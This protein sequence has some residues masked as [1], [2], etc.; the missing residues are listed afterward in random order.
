MPS[1]GVERR[2]AAIMFTDIVGYT[3]LMARDEEAARSARD[4]HEEVVRPLVGRYHG[5]WIERTGDE[6]LS[7]F[8]SALDA[9]NCALAI[10]A[11]LQGDPELRVR[12]GIHQGDVTFDAGGVSGDGVN[13]AARVRP[14]AEAGGICISDEVHH[15]LQGQPDLELESLGERE[16]KHIG[17]PVEV[18]AVK[19]RAAPPRAPAAV[20]AARR[21]SAP[22]STVLALAAL[23]AV[24]LGGWW[25]KR[26]AAQLAPIRSIAVLPLENLSGDPEQEYFADGMTEALIGDLAKLGSLSVISRTSVMRYK[27]SDKSLPEIARELEVDGVLEGTVMRVGDRVRITAQLIDARNDRHLWADRYDREI[28]DVLALQ[29][30]VARAVAEQVRLELT[31]EESEVLVVRRSIDPRAYDAYLRGLQLRGPPTL[32]GGW[33]P[34][35]ITHFERAVELDPGFAEG[36]AALAEVRAFLGVAA[37]NLLY[38][39]EFPKAREAAQRALDL[40]DRLGQ[41]HAILG[42]IRA[43]YDWDFAGAR[44]AYERA[45]KLSPGDAGT[46]NSYAGYLMW[47]EGRPEEAVAISERIVR[48]A[49]FDLFYRADRVRYFFVAHQYLRALDEVERVRELAPDFADPV[50]ANIYFMLGRIEEEYRERIRVYKQ[51]GAS[52]EWELAA[53]ERGWAKGGWRGALR[54]WLGAAEQREGHTPVGIA[55]VYTKIGETEEAFAWLER[56]YRARDPHLI[57][58]KAH[59]LLDPLR[60]DPR[61]DDLVRRIGFPES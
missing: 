40:D 9:V 13:V 19:G 14:L 36:Y 16:L 42:N 50:I 25:W 57:I 23:I 33:G 48:I 53:R 27:R 8:R 32:V 35:A 37:W 12:I 54:A 22:L 58:L 4:R 18:F 43:W 61:F 17:R 46:L 51:C 39:T 26:G 45:L 15:S 11:A 44:R 28:S 29:S 5:E 21:R 55:L 1:D 24:A 3:A 47:A 34:R 49:P 10:Q 2:L 52:C 31:P 6:T 38:R 30:D 7:S 20:V 59:P 41:A 56:A 60:S